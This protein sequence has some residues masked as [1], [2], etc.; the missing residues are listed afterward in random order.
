MRSLLPLVFFFIHFQVFAQVFNGFSGGRS[1]AL[2]KA[3]VILSDE[4]SILN[5]IGALAW[6][7]EKAFFTG[8]Q[9][10]FFLPELNTIYFGAIIP[11]QY[12]V[13]GISLARFGGDLY[14]ETLLGFGI[15]HKIRTASIGFK[16][17]YLQVSAESLGT[18]RT[19]VAEMGG[20]MLLRKDFAIGAHIYNLNRAKLAEFQDERHPT[21]MKV[22]ASYFP[23]K[24]L[25]INLQTTKDI[26]FE[27][28]IQAGIEY[29]ITPKIIAR[30]GVST[31]P[32]LNTFG[33]GF[34]WWNF[35]LDYALQTHT[36]LQPSNTFSICYQPLKKIKKT[37]QN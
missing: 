12:G 10:Q 34:H 18:Q 14:Q 36:D 17:N 23:N 24:N 11:I 31:K 7:E 20:K 15:G 27:P 19:W 5:N 33:V 3:D 1:D 6:T 32:F 21:I 22:G 26:D 25:I 37:S 8:Y 13:A 29:A 28:S 30:T 9:N 35:K 16:I 4:F 2:S